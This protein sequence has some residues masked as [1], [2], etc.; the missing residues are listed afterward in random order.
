MGSSGN[1]K[2]TVWLTG[3]SSGLG[4]SCARAFVKAGC[5]VA[6]G[7]RSFAS[8]E[9]V[10]DDAGY[11]LPLDV[12]CEES[13]TSFAKKAVAAGPWGEGFAIADQADDLDF[14]PG[15]F[16]DLAGQR[17][18]Q[19]FA[20]FHPAAGKGVDALGRL[21]GAADQ[22]DLAVAENPGADGE[23]RAGVGKAGHGQRFMI[24]SMSS[25]SLLLPL[26]MEPARVTSGLTQPAACS[27]RMV[28]VSSCRTWRMASPTVVRIEVMV[29]VMLSN[30]AR[31]AGSLES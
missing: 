31:T 26:I 2:E 16:P 8:S 4:L 25:A 11:H 13:V 5:N 3:A 9:G 28:R 29:A 23:L 30:S 22:Q 24:W 18:M 20:E 6:A 27:A 19:A 21:A 14:E 1:R 12:T 17:L 7:A 15:L 10:E